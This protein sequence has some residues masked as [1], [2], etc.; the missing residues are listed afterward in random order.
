MRYFYEKPKDATEH[1]LY[2]KHT[3]GNPLYSSCRLYMIS[4]E[5]GLAIVQKRFN[6]KLKVFF[7]N[8]PDAWIM[9]EI[10]KNPGFTDYVFEH[11]GESTDNIFPTVT[12]R[13]VMYALKMKPLRKEQ[14]ES[15]EKQ[16]L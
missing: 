7:Y 14:W 5:E 12:V 8:A 6:P 4:D 11:A 10:L 9:D 15:Q 16:L 1:S 2:F 3:N 13:Q